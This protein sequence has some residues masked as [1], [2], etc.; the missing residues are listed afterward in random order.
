MATCTPTI[1]SFNSINGD[2]DVI[3]KFKLLMQ[4]SMGD[5]SFYI[6]TKETYLELF[7][8]L[9]LTE[10]EKASIVA[11]N[12]TK[13]SNDMTNVAMQSAIA[14]AKEERDGAYTLA[15]IKAD[16][17]VALA[18]YEKVKSEICLVDKQ[19]ALQCANIT[20]TTSASIRENGRPAEY[21]A[22]GCT[23]KALTAEGLKYEQTKQV[24]AAVYQIQADT[25]RKSG[26]VTIGTGVDGV[27]KGT[28][29]DEDGYTWQ[30][31][32]NAER[33]RIAY[34]DSK[35]NHAANSSASMIGQM[36]SAEISPNEADVQRWRDALDGLLLKHTSTNNL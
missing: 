6:R 22:D 27:T 15:K 34:E 2:L 3:E 8:N 25:Y 32:Q 24:E 9:Q 19:T 7:E 4:E 23:V 11:E 29:G 16:T 12:I 36:L 31:Q 13:M 1:S 26:V 33:Q 18:Q 30:Q 20:A 28:S 5:E 35:L 10:K 14:W 17:E 21:E